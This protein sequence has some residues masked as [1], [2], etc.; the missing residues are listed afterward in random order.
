MATLSGFGGLAGFVAS[1]LTPS[2]MSISGIFWYYYKFQCT[3]KE[4][5]LRRLCHQQE[6]LGVFAQGEGSSLRGSL[7]LHKRGILHS[8]PLQQNLKSSLSIFHEKKKKVSHQPINEWTARKVGT[9]FL[10]ITKSSCR[11]KTPKQYSIYDDGPELLRLIERWLNTRHV[12]SCGQ[13]ELLKAT[14]C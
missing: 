8:Y 2:M 7:L 1:S 13:I 11:T 6:H 12:L 4:E 3:K 14:I 10:L 5:G 9:V